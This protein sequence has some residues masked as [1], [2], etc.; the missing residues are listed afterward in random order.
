MRFC[1]LQRTMKLIR[2]WNRA[3]LH[4]HRRSLRGRTVGL[5]SQRKSKLHHRRN[6][7]PASQRSPAPSKAKLQTRG[8]P[9]T[10]QQWRFIPIWRYRYPILDCIQLKTAIPNSLQGSYP[11]VRQPPATECQTTGDRITRLL[12]RWPISNQMSRSP[13][14]H[15]RLHLRSRKPNQPYLP[16]LRFLHRSSRR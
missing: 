12:R 2:G 6:R 7:T 8:S 14:L 1:G 16:C 11:A 3:L 4:L 15:H 9:W 10:R 5:S 13:N